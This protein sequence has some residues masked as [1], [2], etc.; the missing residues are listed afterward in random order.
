[1]IVYKDD[2]ILI[3]LIETGILEEDKK[4]KV[5]IDISK[6]YIGDSPMQLIKK[7]DDFKSQIQIYLGRI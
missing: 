3:D 7:L 4:Y 1:M 5:T 2:D 6:S